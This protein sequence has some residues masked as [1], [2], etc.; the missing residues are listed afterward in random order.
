MNEDVKII[1]A[2][3]GAGLII[4]IAKILAADEP[5]KLRQAIG[6]A[7]LSAGLGCGAGMVVLL[8]PGLSMVGYVGLS[9]ALASLGASAVEKL[10]SK[11]ILRE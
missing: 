4:G 10:F 8:I 5:I 11:A 7:L 6:R 1:T 9:C 2:I 3:G